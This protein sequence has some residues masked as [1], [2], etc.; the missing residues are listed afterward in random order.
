MV[1]H[2]IDPI[3][4]LL[5]HLSRP[6]IHKTTHRSNR[7]RDRRKTIS[8]WQR[9]HNNTIYETRPVCRHQ[10]LSA[11]KRIA[12]VNMS[13]RY[14]QKQPR[15]IPIQEVAHLPRKGR[16]FQHRK[17]HANLQLDS[18]R[19]GIHILHLKK[20]CEKSRGH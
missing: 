10:I 4:R 5:Q 17:L 3:F 15:Y 16:T 13:E 12:I 1:H 11:P 14:G 7:V 9:Q 18:L 20:T 19:Y 8:L 6:S 2:I